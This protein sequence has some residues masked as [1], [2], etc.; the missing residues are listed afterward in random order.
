MLHRAVFR[1]EQVEGRVGFYIRN[2]SA[3]EVKVVFNVYIIFIVV[4]A[5]LFGK[6]LYPFVAELAYEERSLDCGFARVVVVLSAARRR[7]KN[8]SAGEDCSQH[9]R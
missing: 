7:G 8:K 3:A 1:D 6:I 9:F 2:D 5:P 4:R